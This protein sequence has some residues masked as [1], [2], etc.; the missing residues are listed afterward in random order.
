MGAPGWSRPA[1]GDSAWPRAPGPSLRPASSAAAPARRRA[2]SAS[3]TWPARSPAPKRR[4]APPRR[5]VT[6]SRRGSGRSTPSWRACRTSSPCATPTPPPRPPPPTWSSGKSA[7]R[8]R[9]PRWPWPP[10]RRAPPART[11]TRRQPTFPCPPP[12]TPS[13]RCATPWGPTAPRSRPSGPRRAATATGSAACTPPRRSSPRP[14]RTRGAA[15]A[16]FQR[17]ATT[18]LLLL[19][20][21]E[22]DL[23]DPATAWAPDPTVR[24]A[25]RVEQ[26]LAEVDADDAAWDRVQRDLTHRF[27]ELA[28]ALSRYGHEATADLAEDRYIVSVVFQG[29]RRTPD[30]LVGLLGDEVAHR[31]R[32]LSAKERELLEE[33]LVNEVASQ[34]QELIADAEDQTRRM[35]DELEERPTSI[36]MK[37][38][39]RWEPLPDGPAGLAEARRRL[40]RQASDAWSAED[41]AAVGAFLQERIAAERARDESGTWLE[42]LT[43]ALDYRAWHKFTIERWQDGRWRSAPGPASSGER[44]LTVTL[45]LFAAASAHYRSA[46][47]A[48]PRLVMLD[49]AFAGVDDDARAKCMGLL[50]TFDLDFVMTS[51]R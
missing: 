1:A 37:L 2:A 10:P 23:P 9:K 17:F 44:V 31:E 24:L 34:L 7:S 20:V 3:P 13:R 22:L 51:E 49:E 46:Q 19:A 18:G 50:A 14:R 42:H 38:R 41:R 27:K 28:D 12:W 15:A 16:A 25:R 21:P 47:P 48:A 33:H 6:R 32:V 26:A 36:G 5:P 30:E 35:N 4:W 43:A 8:P 29:Q 11:A 39:F 45:P 40:L